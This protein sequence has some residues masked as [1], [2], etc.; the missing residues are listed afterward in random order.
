MVQIMMN[1]TLLTLA[2]GSVLTLATNSAIAALPVKAQLQMDDANERVTGTCIAGE[3]NSSDDTCWFPDI[4]TGAST[5]G[6]ANTT[7]SGSYFDLAGLGSLSQL[8]SDITLGGIRLTEIQN[9]SGAHAGVTITGSENPAIDDPWAFASNTGMHGASSPVVISAG[10]DGVAGAGGADG[11]ATLDFS[12]WYVAW[13]TS[14]LIPMGGCSLGTFNLPF[15]GCDTNNDGTDDN[16]NTSQAILRCYTSEAARDAEVDANY[17]GTADGDCSVGNVYALDYFAN[18][19]VGAPFGGAGYTLHLEGVIADTNTAPAATLDPLLV[20]MATN[21][22]INIDLAANAPDTDGD[23]IDTSSCVV[24]YTGSRSP[25]PTIDDTTCTV[26]YTDND[27]SSTGGTPDTFTYTIA[28]TLGLR[29]AAIDVEVTLAAG[30]IAPVANNFTV[31][32]DRNVTIS[33]IDIVA[34]SSDADDGLDLTSVTIV[35]TPLNGTVDSITAGGVVTFTPDTDFAGTA[36]FDYT[37]DDLAPRTSNTATVTVNVNIPPI[38]TNTTLNTDR[39]VSVPVNIDN[40]ASDSDGTL[41]D[42][43]ISVSSCID[44]GTTTNA[45]GIITYTPPS[46]VYI[47]VD[48]CDYTVADNT[49]SVSNTGTITV[50]VNNI[51]PLASPDAAS[52]N[53]LNQTSVVIDVADNDSDSDGSINASSIVIVTNA[54]K[55]SASAAGGVVTY[56]YDGTSAAGSDSFTYKV[57]D[58]DGDF[59][60]VTTVTM[61]L[62][63]AS[64]ALP[65]YMVIEAGNV[66]DAS[67][68]PAS[69]QGSW[70]SM[71]LT[72]GAPTHTS[73]AG[74][75]QINVG[76]AQPGTID[77]PI[78]D[79]PWQFSGNQGVHRTTSP[80][81]ELTNDGAGNV[82]M[83]FTGWAVAWGGVANIPL[84]AGLSNGVATVSCAA[85]C[86]DGDAYVLDY[87][88]TVPPGDPSNFGGVKYHLHLE[89]LVLST[90]PKVGCLNNSATYDVTG[91]AAIE[92]NCNVGSSV[93]TP[94]PG[95][96]ATNIGNTT[97]MNL[98]ATEIGIKDPK[99]NDADGQQ[100]VGGC[101]DFV[102]TTTKDYV[103][104]VFH[105]DAAIPDG[106]VFR[107]LINGRWADF[108]T[109]Q[110]DLVGSAV[111]SAGACQGPDG[112]FDIGLRAG[113]QCVF[114]RIFDGGPNDADGVKN[115]TIVDPSGVLSSGSPNAPAGATDGCSMSATPVAL[116]DRADWLLLATF[117]G[118][119]AF[120]KKMGFKA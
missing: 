6:L 5:P 108:D 48:T 7:Q 4:A 14:P 67:T 24:T 96:F 42:A 3:F 114:L 27:G 43:S 16:V 58:N 32:T 29:S 1:K 17:T 99:L 91:L 74:L 113:N 119:L 40:I 80:L 110:G 107:K 77:S 13:S 75:E 59:S 19:P 71:E 31:T 63:A 9:V 56:T 97:G 101:L 23:G 102:V 37:I 8:G 34:N 79:S 76:L 116:R 25:V 120:R 118:L 88:A 39:N 45:A 68:E 12:G 117:I 70:F 36:S 62:T 60:N 52:I 86:S 46:S 66:P 95:S 38:A 89:G 57:Q 69:G 41:N 22:T 98:T 15:S 83:N 109:S 33:T 78:I 49:G 44:S 84:N 20:S 92:D 65:A 11:V 26:S 50:N 2:I 93:V 35:G 47:G 104:L 61:G 111:D 106:A 81:S 54:N 64:T 51:L 30:N 103:D 94:L 53:I 18:V 73:I 10:D 112:E 21:A 72:P 87:F 105:L 82:T 115:G 55:G 28:D 90:P 85:T 100:C